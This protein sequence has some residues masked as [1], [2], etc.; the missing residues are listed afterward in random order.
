MADLSGKCPKCGNDNVPPHSDDLAV[1]G[2][3]KYSKTH[4]LVTGALSALYGAKRVGLIPSKCPKCG[5]TFWA[6]G[7]I[8]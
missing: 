1:K 3:K 5:T 6:G 4:P 2:F 7:T 8:K